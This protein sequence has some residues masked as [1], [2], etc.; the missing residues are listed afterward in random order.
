LGLRYD[1]LIGERH[2]PQTIRF[3]DRHPD[4][5]FIL[6][7]IAKPRIRERILSPWRENILELAKRPNVYCKLSGLI[8]EADPANWSPAGLAP[9][10]DTVLEAFG[11]RRLMFGSDWPV[12]LLGVTYARWLSCVLGALSATERQRVCSATAIEAYGLASV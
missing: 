8:T 11:P 7:H 9:Y 4:Q 5:V 10:I 2:L 1:I 3:V 12:C 6:D